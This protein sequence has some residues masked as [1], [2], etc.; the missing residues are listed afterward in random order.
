MSIRRG[1]LCEPSSNSS[2]YHHLLTSTSR[3]RQERKLNE[4]KKGTSKSETASNGKATSPLVP[5]DHRKS[6]APSTSRATSPSIMNGGGG[7][8]D[9]EDQLLTS[10]DESSLA[11]SEAGSTAPSARQAQREEKLAQKRLSK[12]ASSGNGGGGGGTSIPKSSKGKSTLTVDELLEENALMDEHVE[13]Q[14][15]RYLGV[16]RCRPLGQDRFHCRYWWFDGIGGMEI[17]KAKEDGSRVPYGTGRVFIQGPTREEW[18][19]IA[20]EHVADEEGKEK[21]QVL[22][23]RRMREEVVDREETLVGFGEWAYYETA[24]EV[25]RTSS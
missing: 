22:I 25:S 2:S 21:E 4:E 24:E 14:F 23:E 5:N 8:H 9:D 13:K 7:E 6:P 12:L 10:D 18:E 11:P 20:D 3:C 16:S 1:E 17:T 19:V 15:R